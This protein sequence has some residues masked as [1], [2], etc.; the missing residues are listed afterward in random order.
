MRADRGNG[1]E[2]PSHPG[3]KLVAP[4]VAVDRAFWT[5]KLPS[6]L[7]L[8]TPWIGFAILGKLH[9]IP[10]TGAVGFK[11]FLAA[12]SGGLGAGWFAWAIL[13]P[14]WRLWAYQRVDDIEALKREA[15]AAQII[16]P[17]G[18]WLERT[19]L[20]SRHLRNELRLLEKQKG[21]Q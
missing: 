5:V 21:G 4:E 11:W 20:A 14:R 13:V 6:L 8:F 12:F 17:E 18:H 2:S 9:A 1:F 19:E 7:L 10:G 16:W 3:A 15:V